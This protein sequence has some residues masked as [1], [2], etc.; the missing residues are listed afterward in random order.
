MARTTE[1]EPVT[2]R[3]V[4]GSSDGLHLLIP[5]GT[6]GIPEQV[7]QA[8]DAALAAWDAR[9]QAH[10]ELRAAQAEAQAAPR[11]DEARDRAA[12]AAGQPLP[13][14]RLTPAARQAEQVAERRALAA[15]GAH[16]DAM[17]ALANAVADAKPTWLG[18]ARNAVA[19]SVADAQQA[20]SELGAAIDRLD[21]TRAVANG[22]ETFPEVGGLG[23]SDIGFGHASSRDHELVAARRAEA[24]DELRRGD[25]MG[26]NM[27]SLVSRDLDHLIAAVAVLIAGPVGRDAVTVDAPAGWD[28]GGFAG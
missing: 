26:G 22:L 5:P 23:A 7:Q 8:S 12:A 27:N 15:T 17:L 6:P 18:E 11:I 14:E 13:V 16:R 24:V 2:R 19:E 10:A 9:I 3:Y 4:L 20:L 25:T 1:A 28:R 21:A